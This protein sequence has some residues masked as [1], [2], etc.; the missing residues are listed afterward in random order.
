MVMRMLRQDVE[1]F[2]DQ[3]T[4]EIGP[5]DQVADLGCALT[6]SPATEKF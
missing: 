4:K 3:K 6:P 1:P 5:N 2:G